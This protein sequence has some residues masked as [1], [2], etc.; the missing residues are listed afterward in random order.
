MTRKSTGKPVGRSSTFSGEKEAWL[1]SYRDEVEAA[2]KDTIGE[3]YTR[4]TA[5]WFER[6]GFDLPFGTN[7]EGDPEDSPPVPPP[8]PMPEEEKKRRAEMKKKFRAVSLAWLISTRA[9]IDKAQ[10]IGQWYRNRYKGKRLH[11]AAIRR[12]LG[13]M[14]VLAG[15]GQRPRRKPAIAIYSKRNYLVKIKPEFDKVWAESKGTLP[16]NARVSLSRDYVQKCYD[17][18]TEEVREALEAEAD[19]THHVKLE[20]WRAG[21]TVA[22]MTAEE[23][24]EAMESVSDVAIPM[25]DA[26]SERLG[27]HV[28]IL[29]VGPI[30]SA[31]GEVSLR[32]IFSDVEGR[33]TSKTW[34]Q[35]DRKG[36]SAME[37]SITRYGRALYNKEEC[38][39]RAWPPLPAD[40]LVPMGAP[41]LPPLPLALRGLIPLEGAAPPTPTGAVVPGP[42]VPAVVVGGE[43]NGGAG[44]ME[45]DGSASGMGSGGVGAE[46][47]GGSGVDGGEADNGGNGGEEVVT[48]VDDGID[49]SEWAPALLD[50]HKY[51]AGKNWGPRWKV[52]VEALVEFEWAHHHEDVCCFKLPKEDRPGDVG[53]WFK[54][55]RPMTD[56]RVAGADGKADEF[57]QQL[58][59]WWKELGP[60]R[61]W[62]DVASGEWPD[63]TAWDKHDGWERMAR[64]G[65]NGVML[66]LQCFAWWGQ[67]IWNGGAADGLEGGNAALEADSLWGHLVDDVSWV[68]G[69]MA[70]DAAAERRE[71][72]AR[73]ASD[74][75][76]GAEEVEGDVEVESGKGKKKAVATKKPAGK[77]K[78][79]AGAKKKSDEEGGSKRGKR[80]AGGAPDDQPAAKRRSARGRGPVEEPVVV[81]QPAVTR[82]RPRPVV[83]Q[84]KQAADAAGTTETTGKGAAVEPQHEA[85]GQPSGQ[86][87]VAADASQDPPATTMATNTDTSTQDPQ[88]D[89]GVGRGTN[90]GEPVVVQGGEGEGEELSDPVGA[91]SAEPEGDDPFGNLTAEELLEMELD[92]DANINDEDMDEEGEEEDV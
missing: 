89:K 8:Y 40:E 21:R 23:Y 37:T 29:I 54:E 1:D 84:K 25:A 78:A 28:V 61:R 4:V 47:S 88:V 92:R 51:L 34:A 24:H 77:K 14:R 53:Q 35:H 76:E 91:V 2:T 22:D 55:H 7:V 36:F 41:P 11:T 30:P 5:R 20:E 56:F 32:T 43:E 67:A 79:A 38:R 71:E 19:E 3:L 90:E 48:A 81:V 17:G 45:V 86:G 62:T 63:T 74:E 52:L 70:A 75:N 80:A 58:F 26:L 6:Y 68:L 16:K 87:Q 10:K 59:A 60:L 66:V 39:A 50:V 13:T 82:P 18:E 73:R 27:A 65:K 83:K 49:R 33:G 42:A 64:H 15:P 57:G 12:I 46:S 31:Q 69:H 85:Q 9:P 72:D 44:A